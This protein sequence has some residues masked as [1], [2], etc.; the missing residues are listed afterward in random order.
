[1]SAQAAEPAPQRIGVIGLGR[2]GWHIAA[3]LAGAGHHLTVCDVM[4]GLA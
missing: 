2:M 3:H 1:V 4:P